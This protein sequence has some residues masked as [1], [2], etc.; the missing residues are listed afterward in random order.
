MNDVPN[1]EPASA[2][3]VA[4]NK[5]MDIF[6]PV[7]GGK[8]LSQDLIAHSKHGVDHAHNIETFLLSQPDGY[9][10]NA[11]DLKEE[12]EHCLTRYGML[13]YLILQ[14]ERAA[15]AAPS[16]A[17]ESGATSQQSQSPEP[18]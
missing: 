10:A 2:A 5:T 11:Y 1:Y 3:V 16:D 7:Y 18:A 9:Y 8:W 13:Y 12:I 14:K 6:E 4:I 15:E 17:L